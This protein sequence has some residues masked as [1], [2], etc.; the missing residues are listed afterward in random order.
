[1]VSG[2]I[3]FLRECVFCS[4]WVL[5]IPGPLFLSW[6][7]FASPY[8]LLLLM[9]PSVGRGMNSLYRGERATYRDRG[10]RQRFK[11]V[12]L[13]SVCRGD[14]TGLDEEQMEFYCRRRW[15][16]GDGNFFMYLV[17]GTTYLTDFP[18]LLERRLFATGYVC[19]I[20]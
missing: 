19:A 1:M 7:F 17:I 3:L 2:L 12:C 10:V 15:K 4:N 18:A 9:M 20:A 11:G 8:L 5:S 13:V 6:S 14:P 16:G